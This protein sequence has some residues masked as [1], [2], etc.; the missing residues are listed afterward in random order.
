MTQSLSL[1]VMSKD[2]YRIIEEYRA[3][4]VFLSCRMRPSPTSYDEDSPSCAFV[5]LSISQVVRRS[6][7]K[8][9]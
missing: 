4:F 8:E 9:P 5:K 1:S 7:R 3:A 6:L 2:I